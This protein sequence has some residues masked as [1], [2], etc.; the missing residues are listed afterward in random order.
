M[1][2]IVLLFTLAIGVLSSQAQAQSNIGFRTI[3]ASLGYVS[4]EDLGGTFGLGVFADLGQITP[5]IRLE[6]RV[7]YWSSSE[8]SFGA[9]ASIR[10]ISIGARGKYFFEV[11]NSQI[12]PFAGAGL[13]L[14]FLNAEAS[15]TIPGFPTL[16]SSQSETKLG[17]ELGGGMES[18]LNPKVDFHAHLWYG[19][20]SNASQFSMRVGLSHKLGGG[21][22]RRATSAKRAAP[23]RSSSKP[24]R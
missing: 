22:S 5:E 10:D 23:A 11:A 17:V 12:R 20:V 14:H 13:G 1:K 3:G 21:E 6:P 4:P 16:S 19:I 9:K 15:V 8:E 18:S 2:R 7:E 24:K